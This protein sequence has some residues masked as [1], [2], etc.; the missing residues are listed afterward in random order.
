[1]I[2]SS[3]LV[4][5]VVSMSPLFGGLSLANA[6]TP[7]RLSFDDLVTNP[8]HSANAGLWEALTDTGIVSVTG[9][10]ETAKQAAWDMVAYQHACLVESEQAQAHDFPDGTVRRT[11]ATHTVEGVGGM[12]VLKHGSTTA[13]GSCEAF[14]QATNVF[15]ATT[16]TAVTAFAAEITKLLSTSRGSNDPLLVTAS[17]ESKTEPFSFDTMS[18]IV[19]YGDHLEHFHSY[20]KIVTESSPSESTIDL[21]TDQGIFLAFTPGRLSTTG[22]LTT[23]FFVQVPNGDIDQV[24][25]LDQ[26]ELVFMLGDGVN[27]FVN[28]KLVGSVKKLRAV[29]HALRLE[30]ST[31]QDHQ[32]RVW[33]GLM[34]LPPASSVH[35]VH[36]V[37]FGQIRQGLRQQ[38]EIREEA[39][40]LACSD[41]L[42][43]D[44][45]ILQGSGTTCSNAD[46]LYCWHQCMN[47]TEYQISAGQC[48]NNSQELKCIN[49][50][51]QIST[52]DEHGDFYPGCVDSNASVVTSFPTL[53]NYPRDDSTCTA[54][55]EYVSSATYDHSVTLPGGNGAAFQYTVVNGRQVQGRLSFNGI[56]GYLGFGFAG[57]V[58]N[59]ASGRVLLAMRGGNY[60]PQTGLDLTQGPQVNEY[61]IDPVQDSFRFWDTPYT[62]GSNGT[63]TTATSRLFNSSSLPPYQVTFNDCYTALTF[64][65]ESIAG[66]AFN[67]TGSDKMIWAANDRDTFMQ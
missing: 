42:Q 60:T 3:S 39:L 47:V 2:S 24:N 1:M 13:G 25:F 16:H 20:Q 37:T 38:G 5:V 50:R 49:P 64:T 44:H 32:A 54:F 35:P 31:Q 18:D 67:L 55:D 7:Y 53:P 4:V 58:N 11:L 26:D 34:V 19:K 45:R 15:R 59:M 22:E 62:A 12:Q 65:A 61:V 30:S 52:G 41:F 33:Y 51:G 46:E 17:T 21:H 43:Q 56:F 63:T 14:E 36:G 40:R 57:P 6:L 8:H 66:R 27:Q 9:L 28:D 29:P 10:P 48:Q 23:G